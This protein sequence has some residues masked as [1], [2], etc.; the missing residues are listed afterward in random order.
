MKRLLPVIL[1]I[2]G[3]AAGT[4]AGLFLRP[5]PPDVAADHGGEGAPETGEDQGEPQADE[6]A[7]PPA[8]ERPDTT[9]SSREYVKLNNQFVVPVVTD[10]KV[11]AL[12]VLSL[13]IEVAAGQKETVFAL[14]PKLRDSFLQVLF[15]H[16]NSGG[17]DG[18]FTSGEKMRDLRGSLFEAAVAVLGPIASDV[19]VI[20]IVRQDV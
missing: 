4:G 2:L 15:N 10:A 14:E 6:H 18:A 20:D 11:S 16:A 13:S 3:L 5:A 1:A 12:I 17:F 9:Q 19:L 7:E 8:T